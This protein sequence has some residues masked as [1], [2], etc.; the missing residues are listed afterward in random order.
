MTLTHCSCGHDAVT[1]LLR[2][3]DA[4][5]MAHSSVVWRGVRPQPS[6][7]ATQGFMRLTGKAGNSLALP[8]NVS[9]WY[10]E[11]N[12]LRLHDLFRC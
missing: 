12:R 10:R 8:Q 7:R 11:L 9:Q 3:T 4:D 5:R 6:Q 2:L 1:T